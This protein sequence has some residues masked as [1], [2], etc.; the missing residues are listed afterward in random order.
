MTL[1]ILNLNYLN[2]LVAMVK[3]SSTTTKKRS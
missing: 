3:L 1:V 2:I